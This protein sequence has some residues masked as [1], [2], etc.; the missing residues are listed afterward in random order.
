MNNGAH[1]GWPPAI[2]IDTFIRLILLGGLLTWCVLI[3]A[4]FT[5]ILVWS[6]ILSVALYPLFSAM[7]RWM[8]GRKGLA[9][10][11]LVLVGL[12]CIAVPGYFTGQSLVSSLQ[13]LRA[14]L[15]AD[16]LHV[17]QLPPEWYTGT[18]LKKIIADRWPASDGAVAAMVRDHAD[19]VKDIALRLVKGLASFTVDL[20]K[21][22]IAFVAAGVMLAFAREGG[23]AAERFLDRVMGR[24]GKAMVDLAAGTVRQVAKGIL[25]VAVLQSA[26]FAAGVFIAGVPAAG[27]LTIAALLLCIV[28]IGVGPIGIGV[29]IY[30]WASMTTL[31]AVL[32]TIWMLVVMISD[33]ILKPLLLGRGAAVPTLVIF[34]G[35]IGGFILSG[36]IGLFTGAVVLSIGYRLMMSWMAGVEKGLGQ[37]APAD[38][39]A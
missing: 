22:I 37:D 19:Q 39:G 11:A 26:M 10:T 33:N 4:P 15:T 12:T 27:F 31:P 5:T 9:A 14:H 20:L 8:G 3:L 35:A 17:P 30:A 6:V 38:P 13:A 2:A 28:Q 18:G 29:I 1:R 32:L 23:Q 25:G 7:T 34:L 16:E 24:N 36:F 21:L